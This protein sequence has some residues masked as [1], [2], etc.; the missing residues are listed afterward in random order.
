MT[1]AAQAVSVSVPAG[2]ATGITAARFR[3][4]SSGGLGPTGLAADGE[5]EDH[6]VL[7]RTVGLSVTKT[8]STTAI[9]EPGWPVDF[10]V[11]VPTCLRR[12]RCR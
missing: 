7:I 1:G 11:R 10:V 2:A 8:P 3:L 9:A 6:A 12:A 5:V 4:D